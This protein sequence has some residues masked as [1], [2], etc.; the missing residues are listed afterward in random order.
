[1][2]PTDDPEKQT[3]SS[4]RPSDTVARSSDRPGANDIGTAHDDGKLVLTEDEALERV[5]R[6]PHDKE[7]I[8]IRYSVTDEDNPRNWGTG[9]RWYVTCLVCLFNVL[10]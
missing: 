8:Y 6:L 10:T 3:E 9:K 2:M 1:M 7:P 5:R 4:E